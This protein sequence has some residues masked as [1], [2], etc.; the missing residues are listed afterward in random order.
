[1]SASAVFH[2]GF[3]VLLAALVYGAVLL[4]LPLGWIVI[5]GLGANLI[6]ILMAGSYAKPAP[7]PGA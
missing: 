2:I 1:M 5:G 6:G 3:F 4:R 7:K